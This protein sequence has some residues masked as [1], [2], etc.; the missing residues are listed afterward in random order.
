MPSEESHG[1]YIVRRRHNDYTKAAE[2]LANML[3]SFVQLTR[4]E[5]ISQRN[6]VESSSENFDWK[7]LVKYYRDAYQLIIEDDSVTEEI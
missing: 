5:R 3:F 1:I 2:S 4:R 6:M 7:Y